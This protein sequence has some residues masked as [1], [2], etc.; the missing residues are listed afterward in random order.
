MKNYLYI[1]EQRSP[2]GNW[3][4]LIDDEDCISFIKKDLELT[5]REL[6]EIEPTASFQ[7]TK[8]KREE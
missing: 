1:I 5:L 7:I 8:F 3:I 4:P 6:E 2:F